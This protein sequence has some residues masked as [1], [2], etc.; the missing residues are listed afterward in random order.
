LL[1]VLATR[2]GF[3]F[4]IVYDSLPVIN[5][6]GKTYGFYLQQHH[7]VAC[8]ISSNDNESEHIYQL[9]DRHPLTDA[10]PLYDYILQGGSETDD[11]GYDVIDEIYSGGDDSVELDDNASK[12]EMV[13]GHK[14]GFNDC[15]AGAGV[16]SYRKGRMASWLYSGYS[17]CSAAQKGHVN[18]LQ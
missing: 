11:D 6:L 18:G 12:K 3:Q 1:V 9:Y 8:G 17:I 7:S 2:F 14:C 15:K 4:F 16:I 13:S 10:V 5:N